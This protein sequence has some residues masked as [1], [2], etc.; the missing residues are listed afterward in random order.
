MTGLRSLRSPGSIAEQRNID[1]KEIYYE[2]K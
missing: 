2:R 1:L